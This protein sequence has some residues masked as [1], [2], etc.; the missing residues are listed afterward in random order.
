MQAE[1]L[2]DEITREV[3]GQTEDQP[4]AVRNPDQAEEFK[5]QGGELYPKV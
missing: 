5:A 2:L 1:V 4:I 3:R